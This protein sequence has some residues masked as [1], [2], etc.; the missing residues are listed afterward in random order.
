MKT[1]PRP[2]FSVWPGLIRALVVVVLL[3]SI[4]HAQETWTFDP[5]FQRT[6][7]RVT[8][9]SPSGVKVLSSGKVLIHSI[10]GGIMSGANGQRIGALVRIDPNTGAIDPTWSLDPTL[11]G[12][13][14]LGVAEALDGKIYYSTAIIGD[15]A[16]ATDPAVNRLIRLNTDG[17]RDTSFNSPIFGYAARF[18]SI[19]PDGKIIVC[20][21]AIVLSGVPQ[22]GSILQTVRLNTDGTLDPTFQSP[23]FQRN[24]TDPPASDLGVFGN[25]VIDPATG[26]IYFCGLFLFV[27]GQP[28]QAIVRCNAD[29]TVDSSFVPTG[30]ISGG[31]GSLGR[32][33]VLQTGG[34]VVLGGRRLRTPAGGATCYALLR[35]NTDGT[36]DS[37]FTLFPTTDSS[38]IALVP[39]YFGPR[40]IS[41]LPG[42]NI[43]TSDTRV[44]R[45]LPDGMLDSTFTPLDYSSPYFTPNIG[46]I[47][48][49]RFDLDPNTGAAYIQNPGPLYARLGGMP[50]PG[51][52][53]KLNLNGTIDS[54]F[55]PP[56]VEFED[57]AP[58]VQIAANGA[59]YVSG[60]HTD[61]GNA[62]NGTIT[63]LL[64]DGT[65]D[66]AYS[67]DTLPFADK[68]AAGFAP[69]PDGSAY[70]IYYSGSFNGGY[71]FSNMA[72]LLPTGALDPSFRLSSALQTAFSI[73]A[74]DGND[75]TK[76]SLPQISSASGGGAYLFGGDAQET[77]NANGNLK[78]TRVNSDGT[79]DMSVPALGFP[80][81]EVT[82][83][84]S[85]I[86]GGSTGYLHRLAQTADGGF[87]ILASVA[88]FPTFT[89]A[90][91]NYQII[92]LRADGSRD[93]NFNSPSLT[94]TAAPFLDFPV[95][96][97]PVTGI[98]SQPPNGFYRETVGLLPVS[99]AAMFPDG[100]VLLAGNFLLTGSSSNYSLAK[101]TAAGVLD[102]SFSPPVLENR[103]R[104]TRP[105][106]VTNA[107]VAPDGKVW[108]LGRFDTIGGNPAPGVARLNPDGTLDNTFGLTQVGYYDSF[109]DFA[110]VV[111]ANS[112]IAYLVGTFRRP[113]EPIPFSVTRIATP[114]VITSPLTANG[115]MD[116]QF[117]YQFLASGAISFSVSNLPAGLTFNSN[118]RAITGTPTAS[119]V[120]QVG[121]SASNG[122]G[123]TMATL[124]IT[125][126]PAPPSGPVI[127]SGTSATGRVGQP[128]S[129]HVIATGGTAAARVSASGLPAGLSIDAVTGIISGTP[130]A[131]GSS[132]VTLTVTDGVFTTSS[133]LQLTFTAD[134]ALPVITS[135]SLAA[136]TPGMFFSYTITAPSSAD[137][138]DPTIFAYSGTLPPGLS[139][140]AA[141]GTIS[142]F[143]T[144]PL[145]PELAGGTLLG[146]IQ[147][148]A[149]NSHGTSTFNL[150]LRAAATGAVNIAT[151]LPVGTGANVLIGSFIVQGNA[152]KV[153]LV[154]AI[155]PS[156]TNLGVANALQ[157]PTLELHDSAHPDHVV[158]NDNWKDT[159]EQ[160]IRDTGIAPTDDR[161]SAIVIALDPG[162]YTAIVAGK[163]G[164]TGIG[165][166][167]VYD[168]GTAP[169]GDGGTAKLA[170]IA[171]RGF[172]DT[173]NN[174][175]IGGFIVVTQPTRVVIRAIGPSLSQFGV[176]DAL[177]NPQLELHDA[178]SLIAQND[179]WQTTQIGGIITSDQVAEI[180][181]S[182]L[183]PTNAAESAII[184]T[185]QPGSYTA[186][187]RGTNNTT[188]NGL[189][190]VYALE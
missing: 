162:S 172:V 108:V 170:N 140:D 135:P 121:L 107:R 77:V 148:F 181:N 161:E 156:L 27:N 35:F 180:Q 13:G 65:H 38:G 42:G 15:F 52:I 174:V 57:F 16:N 48:G 141:T 98:T 151:R 47:A 7:L 51:E 76:L 56:I 17:S 96:F 86:T 82:R 188:G 114:P 128:F 171:T 4:G 11:T 133:I 90:P 186:I 23:N 154:R 168:L 78:P 113:G 153:V 144:G 61:F 55:L 147:L 34:K 62:A 87:I 89:G 58:D 28:R 68:Q 176:P 190:E 32:A 184:A 54:Q 124:T 160:I 189:V 40:H 73:N 132:A 84:A 1:S 64:A 94:S 112:Q 173:G 75:T 81:G 49:F 41:A 92:K 21:G 93:T 115:N 22:P 19:Q 142:G 101:L 59:V 183:A 91:Y 103:A 104:P 159:Q 152:P 6:P 182:Q 3:P 109:G 36:L 24:A 138:S 110:D 12:I 29:G 9:E 69:L 44:L 39:G 179:D 33:M 117:T 26:K 25:P 178:S 70:V 123:T 83:D 79:E 169:L 111:F 30:L 31:T 71:S 74:F 175:M 85:G 8:S 150:D 102:T 18:V 88:P 146:N 37:T 187:V 67:L 63:R 129:F 185:L 99:S 118:L 163:D 53:T 145:G 137:P 45:F 2:T 130:T 46:A 105:T 122:V 143:Y 158:F 139:F 125:V 157:D 136:V 155:G 127:I 72:R 120:F 66:P 100:S 106:V 60:Y 50:V 43:L 134:P 177:A 116:Q 149:T 80:V 165:L 5:T 95:L 167:E 119:G 126:Q 20:S 164:S 131:E 97:D 10:N 166:V 14:F